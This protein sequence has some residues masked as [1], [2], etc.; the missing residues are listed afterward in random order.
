MIFANSLGLP[1]P[2]TVIRDA[3]AYIDPE[4]RT[5]ILAMG[6]IAAFKLLVFGRR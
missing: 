2:S 6:A 3:I 4:L 5:F 1:D